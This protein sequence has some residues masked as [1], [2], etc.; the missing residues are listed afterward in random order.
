MQEDKSLDDLTELLRK[1]ILEAEELV[2]FAKSTGYE[3]EYLSLDLLHTLKIANKLL[4]T[5]DQEKALTED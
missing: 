2:D 4:K 3:G 5:L 1:T